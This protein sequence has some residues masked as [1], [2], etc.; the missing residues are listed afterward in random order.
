MS[1]PKIEW[2]MVEVDGEQLEQV[3]TELSEAD[4]EIFTAQFTGEKWGVVARK[5]K[6]ES[7][8]KNR[9]GFS[10]PC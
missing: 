8:G 2:K 6:K 3:L 9:M 10:A 4:F 5:F 1:I 7:S